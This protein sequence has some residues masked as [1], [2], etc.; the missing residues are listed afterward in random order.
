MSAVQTA[1]DLAANATSSITNLTILISGASGFVAA[2]VLNAFLQRGYNVRGT[3][4]SDATAEKVMKSHSKYLKQLSFAIV[5]D[6][7]AP[8]AFDEAVKDV[9]GVIHTASP[10]VMEVENNER[11]LLDP[12]VKGTTEILKAIKKNNPAVKRVVITS[13]FAAIV[14]ISK[15]NRPGHTY[16]EAD[17][18]PVTWEAAKT[19]PG[20]VAYSASKT[21]AE[22]AAW[23]FVEKE[24]PNFTVA[25]INPPMIYGPIE[26]GVTD[27]AHLNTSAAD[28]YRFINGS[29]KEIPETG[30]PAWV[31]VRDVGEAHA[32]AYETAGAAQ[33]RY[34]ITSG[35]MTYREIC[36]IIREEVL[37]VAAKVPQSA[38]GAKDPETYN[39]SNAKATTEL[40]MTFIPLR[41]SITDTVRSLLKLEQ[42][43]GKQS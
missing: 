41:Q 2:H 31:D 28:I 32:R 22:K 12:A 10:F 36:D 5:K 19:G 9:D 4:R 33:Q 30:F 34:F 13:S 25:T 16:T 24:K 6:V 29:T 11:D 14:D 27:L 35:N 42:S 37:E 20:G 43:V 17:W 3:V 7:A 18:N 15:G 38:P 21:F 23:D 8:G 40:G 1:K 39:V 26:H